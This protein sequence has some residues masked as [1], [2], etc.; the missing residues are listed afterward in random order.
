MDILVF[1]NDNVKGECQVDG[2]VDGIELLSYSHGVAMQVTGDVS[3]VERTSGRPNL[4]DFTISKYA[5]SSTPIFN[6][7]CCEGASIGDVVITIARNAGGAIVPFIVYTM[8]DVVVSSVSIGGGGGDKPVETVSLNFTSIQ[9]T[10]T[11][12]KSDATKEGNVSS[13][14]DAK[15]NKLAS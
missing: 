7:K 6:Q 13:K 15:T 14:W 8:T 12:Q 5:D 9:W 3:N 11:K 4:Q 1:K 10:F 2:F